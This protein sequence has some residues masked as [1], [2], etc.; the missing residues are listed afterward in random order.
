MRLPGGRAG[1]TRTQSLINGRE[2]PFAYTREPGPAS[3]SLPLSPASSSTAVHSCPSTSTQQRESD[4][5]NQ[6]GLCCCH[7]GRSQPGLSL[8]H[9]ASSGDSHWR[10]TD[11][12]RYSHLGLQVRSRKPSK[13]ALHFGCGT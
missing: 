8:P 11:K 7:R 2:M 4:C 12:C 1:T 6:G 13:Q 5:L 10:D 3:S 9:K